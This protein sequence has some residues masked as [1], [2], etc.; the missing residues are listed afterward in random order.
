MPSRAPSPKE[1]LRYVVI[2]CLLGW[3]ISIITVAG[4]PGSMD[5]AAQW[6]R[7]LALEMFFA[8][9]AFALLYAEY[10]AVEHY[11]R[12]DLNAR[13][14]YVQVVGCFA[15]LLWGISG[16][17][18]AVFKQSGQMAPAGLSSNALVYIL[19]FG[20]AAF[21]ANI[22]W[23]YLM[24]EGLP[25]ARPAA[26]DMRPGQSASSM[27]ARAAAVGGV[28]VST[29]QAAAA[30]SWSDRPASVFAAAAGFFIVLGGIFAAVGP[31]ATR[32]PVYWNG[33]FALV[34][35]GFLWMPLALPFAA[36]AAFYWWTARTSGRRFDRGATRIHLVCTLLAVLECAR[37]YMAWAATT[38][39]STAFREPVTAR[40]FFGVFA[41]SLLAVAAL[42]WNLR[43]SPRRSAPLA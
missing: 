5:P 43:A 41:F 16:Y 21:V 36:F 31:M 4:H 22:L 27:A 17:V 37:V 24:K 13:L 8:L 35:V 6:T 25:P 30:C 2:F 1:L 9:F 12:R 40:N 42:V 28:S 20:E 32:M 7:Q 14:G 39:N 11:V 23:S 15:L 19:L 38:A 10:A 18:S 29:A 3:G 34:S 33:R 26:A